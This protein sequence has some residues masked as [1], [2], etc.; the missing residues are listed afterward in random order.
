M[1]FS[2]TGGGAFQIAPFIKVLICNNGMTRSFDALR[3]VHLGGRMDEGQIVWS[4]DTQ[5]KELELISAQAT[6]A[7]ETFLSQDY[8]DKVAAELD[9]KADAQLERPTEAVEQIAK[10][11]RY[12]DEEKQGILDFF[13]RG[14]D[15]RPVG[16][17]QAVTAYAQ[18]VDDPER[19]MELEDQAFD[20]LDR[21][22][23][24][25]R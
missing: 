11:L 24:L 1:V 22:L 5:R 10:G 23:V 2:E 15:T 19:A 9:G 16:V 3:K 17:M 14:A 13:I 20:V 6:D 18:T 7:V 8:I 21:A 4:E 12:S 25:A